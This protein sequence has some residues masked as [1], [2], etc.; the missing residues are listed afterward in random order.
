MPHPAV[1]TPKQ[2]DFLAIP[3][4]PIPYHLT[5]RILDILQSPLH[6]GDCALT[7]EGLNTTDNTRFLRWG[8]EI[9]SNREWRPY[10]KGGGYKKWFGNES[11][12]V[13]WSDNGLRL[14]LFIE[15]KYKSH[16]SK[17]VSG[18]DYYDSKGWVYS[19]LARG[20]LGCRLKESV[21]IFD[22]RSGAIFTKDDVDIVIIVNCRLSSY[23][24]RSLIPVIDFH[25]GYVAELPIIKPQG[26]NLSRFLASCITLKRHLV[27]TDPTERSFTGVVSDQAQLDAIAALLH[28]LEGINEA[29]V[30]AAYGVAGDDMRAVLEETGIPAGFHP[31]LAGYDALPNVATDSTDTTNNTDI[32]QVILSSISAIRAIRGSDELARIK[33]R[34]RALYEAGP[35]TKESTDN[36]DNTDNTDSDQQESSGISAIRGIGAIR[37][38]RGSDEADEEDAVVTGAHIPI[39]TETFLE[40]LS[41][42]MELH[43]I[44]V[45]WLLE[46][47]RSEGARCKPEERRL[48]EDRL[49]VLVLRLLGYRWPAELATDST[50]N[51]DNNKVEL[52]GIRA[53]GAIRGSNNHTVR[54][55]LEAD[56]DGIIPLVHLG[57]GEATLAERLRVRLRAEDGETG[58]QRTEHLLTELTG[59]T[60]LEDWCARLFWP[61]HVKQFKARPIAWQIASRPAGAGKKRG[62]RQPPLFACLLFY[63]ATGGDALARLRT[64]YIEPL[65]RREESA[66]AEALGKRNSEGA[67]LANARVEE[68][69]D[70]LGRLQQ[71]EHAGF[72]CPELDALLTQEPLDRWSSD[73]IVM[74]AST[75]DLARQERAW[76]VDL[77]DG[78][79]VNIAPLQLAGTLAGEVLKAADAK[80][81]IADRARW[82][83]DERRWVRAGKLPRCGWM[84]TDVPESPAW[85]RLAPEREAEQRKLKEKRA[86]ANAKQGQT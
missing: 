28:T 34:L 17:R 60:S 39:P 20:S 65:L 67:A 21:T 33:T 82:R 18:I 55:S 25:A 36:T 83:A 46:E 12:I 23:L 53:I 1:S 80:K 7:I 41:V 76:Q 42:R 14:K 64:Q 24:L 81:A 74:L 54:G 27:A 29:E 78:V 4:S 84:D 51:T 40:E 49:S 8:W 15:E 30:F 47:L 56:A 73:G 22:V 72:A 86:A 85:T 77:N 9:E 71:V 35:G 26:I 50:D 38:I 57:T 31:L 44:S 63:H 13:R 5:R 69:R 10:S 2:S 6:L 3:G 11:L 66:L 43:P 45:Y 75:E 79:R 52:S 68:L 59:A 61:R 62:T 37:A 70:L 16:W 48:L 58:A 32:N 19:L